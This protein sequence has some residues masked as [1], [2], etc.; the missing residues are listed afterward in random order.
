MKIIAFFPVRTV[1]HVSSR[2]SGS[3]I[4]LSLTARL[5]GL[6]AGSGVK[7]IDGLPTDNSRQPATGVQQQL[8]FC[9]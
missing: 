8:S 1:M 2:L 5:S 7:F 3:G 6:V 4:L 9:F